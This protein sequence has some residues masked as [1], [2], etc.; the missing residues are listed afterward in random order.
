MK[1][2]LLAAM[3]AC[4]TLLGCM[5]AGG[6]AKDAT[7]GQPASDQKM[8]GQCILDI[9]WKLVELLGK[10]VTGEERYPFILLHGTEGFISG[11]GGCNSIRGAYELKPGNRIRFTN[12]ASTLMA[13]PDM[14][15]DVEQEFFN[16]LDMADNFACDGKTLFLHKARMAPL[17][18]FEA[19]D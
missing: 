10:P 6:P 1:K 13:C 11:Y 8:T 18:R 19:V 16:V 15:G 9:R 4:T 7:P 5:H 14:D 3:L 2:I 12:M 17:A